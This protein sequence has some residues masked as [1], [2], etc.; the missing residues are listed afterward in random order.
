MLG[1]MVE[2]MNFMGMGTLQPFFCYKMRALDRSHSEILEQWGR[3]SSSPKVIFSVEALQ[4]KK[5]S[6]YLEERSIPITELPL[7]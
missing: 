2:P 1:K 7:P 5:G 4:S 3:H 6:P